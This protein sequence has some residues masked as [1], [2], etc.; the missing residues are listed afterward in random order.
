MAVAFVISIAGCGEGRSRKDDSAWLK[1]DVPSITQEQIDAVLSRNDYEQISWPEGNLNYEAAMSFNYD[2][3][4]SYVTTRQA[5]ASHNEAM[6][7]TFKLVD[8]N[9]GFD[10]SQYYE[11]R[12]GG[13]THKEILKAYNLSQD[14]G[15]KFYLY[16]RARAAGATHRETLTA[17]SKGIDVNGYATARDSGLS[18]KEVMQAVAHNFDL[19]DFADATK[20][21]ITLR[22]ALD[23]KKHGIKLPKYTR[24]RKAGLSSKEILSS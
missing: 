10:A 3:V 13:A 24:L 17:Y 9:G 23:A 22:E 1:S 20:K 21:G 15:L 4:Y 18:D 19:Y 6:T 14:G 8:P 5:G 2:N 16:A 7:V 11:A 12:K